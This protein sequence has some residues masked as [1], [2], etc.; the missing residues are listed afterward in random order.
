MLSASDDKT[1]R[2]WQTSTGKELQR[3]TGHTGGVYFAAFLPGERDVLTAGYDE[4]IRVWNST[5]GT[6]ICQLITLNDGSYVVVGPDHRYD[7]SLSGNIAHLYWWQQ[8]KRIPFEQLKDR[9][10]VPGLAKQLLDLAK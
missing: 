7:S 6:E 2:L 8:G 1:A 3:F 10:H 4:T 9:Y 5:T